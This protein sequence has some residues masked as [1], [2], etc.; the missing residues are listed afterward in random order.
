MVIRGQE[1][2]ASV[3][4]AEL[5]G[6]F[7]KYYFDSRWRA[8]SVCTGSQYYLLLILL[9]ACRLLR[10]SPSSKKAKVRRPCTGMAILHLRREWPVEWKRWERDPSHRSGDH[11]VHIRTKVPYTIATVEEWKYVAAVS[12]RGQNGARI[13][14]P[15]AI[16]G[17][18]VPPV[19]T[20]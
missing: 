4:C 6:G 20:F 12:N 7:F 15:L 9:W 13:S 10:V 3:F 8:R 17:L 1:A 18:N 5:L 16:I 11:A 14:A 19:S 2:K